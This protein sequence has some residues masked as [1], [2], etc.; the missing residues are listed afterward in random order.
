MKERRKKQHAYGK[1]IAVCLVIGL[2]VSAAAIWGPSLTAGSAQSSSTTTYNV[3]EVTTGSVSTTISG[4]GS[5]SPV[6]SDTLSASGAGT[7]K[8]VNYAAGDT[9]SEGD[10]IAVITYQV[11]EEETSEEEVLAPYDGVLLEMPIGEGDAVE[12]GAELAL[13]MG[14]D[15]F[16]MGIA[17]DELNIS[18]VAIGQDV[19]ITIDAVEGDY[20]GEVASISY[21]GTTS[22]SVTAYQITAAVEY[23]EGVYPGMSVSAQI[24]IEDS[25][26]GLIVP[27]D[28][29]QTSGDTQY[30]YLAPSDAQS[31]GSYDEDEISLS[32]LTRVEVE[33]GMSDGSYIRIDS[34]ELSE[35]AL[36]IVPQVTSTQT[37][38]SDTQSGFMGGGMNFGDFDFSNFDPSQMPQGM[39]MPFMG[40]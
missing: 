36:I 24:V 30:V 5:L 1:W 32:D 6:T 21:N 17:V 22:G 34:E 28:A 15:G 8:S 11:S 31:G 9:V 10:V 12:A 25:G 19:E 13:L 18:Q 2:V 27:V 37:G 29:V 4:S 39:D 33:S 16:S 38:S 35:G 40:S 23:V 26:E 3:E 14:L 20:T 7:V